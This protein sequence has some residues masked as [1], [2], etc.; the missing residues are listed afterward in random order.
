MNQAI[1]DMTT[2]ERVNGRPHGGVL[3]GQAIDERAMRGRAEFQSV[4]SDLAK[5]KRN[6]QL[7][8]FGLLGTTIV[9]AVGLVS[10]SRQSRITPYVVEV[11]RLGRAQAFGPA[12]QL[13]VTDQRIVRA[14]IASFVRDIRTVLG[15]PSAQA[16]LVRRAYAFVDQDAGLF[17]SQYYTSPANDPRL[18]GRELTRLVDVSSVL[19]VPGGAPRAATAT[20]K[21][22][23]TETSLPRGA[24]GLPSESAWEGYFTTRTVPP[25]TAE[26]ITVNPLGLYIT[27]INWTQLAERRARGV[28]VDSTGQANGSS[29]SSAGVNQR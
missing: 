1:S 12:E 4:F 22:S 28:P 25:T 7:V 3:A 17:L 10:S 2:T 6:W 26:R 11:D 9:L 15:D 24:G 8:A 18:L 19:P 27:S 29:P 14:E 21:V 20:W 5:G 13:R 23:W 16:D